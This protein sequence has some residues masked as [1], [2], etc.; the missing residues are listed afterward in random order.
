MADATQGYGFI[1]PGDLVSR[2]N[3]TASIVDQMLG[4]VRTINL[5][6]VVSLGET[7]FINIQPLVS[8]ADS[9][10]NATNHGT[11]N[12]VPYFQ[13]RSGTFGI[14]LVPMIGDVG[15]VLF[16]DRDISAALASLALGPPPSGRQFDMA[17]AIYLGGLGISAALTAGIT[18]NAMGISMAD[19]FGNTIAMTAAGIA[20]TGSSVKINGIDFSTHTHGGVTTGSDPTG[21]PI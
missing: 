5:A 7:G 15:I 20:I 17:D 13:P 4:R 2:F 14:D 21:P 1:Q 12:N 8:M 10:G 16:C 6:R 9:Q 18:I 11:I 3:S 19:T